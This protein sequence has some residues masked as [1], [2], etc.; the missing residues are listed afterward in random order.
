MKPMYLLL[1]AAAAFFLLK[2]KGETLDPEQ[3]QLIAAWIAK[4]QATP[5]WIAQQTLEAQQKGIPVE[6]Q[7]REAA[8]WVISQGWVL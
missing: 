4:I 6:Q 8:I 5:E 3:E 2:P 1:A 7:L